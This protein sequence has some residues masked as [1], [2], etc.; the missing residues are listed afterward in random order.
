M[1]WPSFFA[2]MFFMFAFRSI[3]FFW[4]RAV[5]AAAEEKIINLRSEQIEAAKLPR[6]GPTN[7]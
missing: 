5:D 3:G 1:N 6:K 7:V 4:K 2:G